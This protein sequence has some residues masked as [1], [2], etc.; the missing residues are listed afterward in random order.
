MVDWDRVQQL[1]SQGRDW[2]EIAADPKVDFHP[3]A[4]A[5]SPGRA[6]RAMYHRTRRRGT[7]TATAPVSKRVE[8]ERL[9]QKWTLARLGYLLVPVVGL[10]L[11]LAFVAPSPVGLLVPW[12]PYLALVFAGVVLILLYALL[13]R[14]G[15]RWSAVYRRT[16]V[17]GVVVGLV[18]AGGVGLAGALIFGC[19]Y[20]PP[21]SSL[22]TYGG[23]GWSAVPAS[24]WQGGGAPVVFFYGA[25]WCP[26]CSA[27]SWAIY[28]ALSE[29]ATVSN[30]PL[31]HSYI[32]NGEPYP[33][34]PEVVLAA[35]TLG[36]RNGHGPAIDF[37]V[38]EYNGGV[39]GTLP[40]TASCY[41]SAYVTAYATGIPFV[42]INGQVLHLGTL[43]DPQ[44][45]STWNYA[46]AG[47]S[48]PTT[49]MNSITSESGAPWSVVQGQAWWMMAYI[50]KYLGWTTTTISTYGGSSYYGWSSATLSA[51]TG[52][53][54]LIT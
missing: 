34:T 7:P 31:S 5:G 10:W 44:D 41:Q 18:F 28:K 21:S 51:V 47:T 38:A 22:S 26:Y 27:S 20:L 2:A 52:D 23:S 53:L 42:V 36:P 43:I 45:L 48:G 15:A 11:A 3:D 17:A 12:F 33:G 50:A 29:F 54:A 30:T 35:A 16:V 13:R 19:P 39:D 40:T 4:S 24:S 9:E 32:G 8:R 1:R 14:T 46:T 37:Q 6:L 25:T 49:V